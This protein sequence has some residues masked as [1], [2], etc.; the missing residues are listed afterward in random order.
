MHVLH[1]LILITFLITSL[2]TLHLFLLPLHEACVYR[3]C[4]SQM[5]CCSLKTAA[6][7][8]QTSCDLPIAQICV[9]MCAKYTVS[10]PYMHKYILFSM[11][12]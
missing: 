12:I 4:S 8:G 7:A 2:I 11:V 6:I 9:Q 1:E 10:N 5:F 3:Q